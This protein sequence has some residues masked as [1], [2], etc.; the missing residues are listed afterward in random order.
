MRVWVNGSF[1]ILHVGHIE[2]LKYA[3]SFGDVWVGLDTDDRIKQ[4]KGENRPYN[5]LHDRKIMMRAIKYV[6]VVLSFDS[7]DTLRSLIKRVKPDI[8][9]I[10]DDYKDKPIIGAEFIPRIEY[11]KKIKGKST[12]N[13]INYGNDINNRT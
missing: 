7:D 6:K 3:N 9:V 2:L 11:F 13:I 12:T 1:D 4:L 8:M 5:S 10:G